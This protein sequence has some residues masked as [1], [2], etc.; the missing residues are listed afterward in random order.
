MEIQGV[1]G[2]FEVTGRLLERLPGLDADGLD[3]G[4]LDADGLDA[5]LLSAELGL[6]VV[7]GD[8]PWVPVGAED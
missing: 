8:V 3:A 4:G 2:T 6:E 5:G 7:N 1:D